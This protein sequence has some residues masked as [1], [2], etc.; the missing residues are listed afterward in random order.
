MGHP[1]F[2]PFFL[3]WQRGK[4]PYFV[5]PVGCEMPPKKMDEEIKKDQDFK[6]IKVTHEYDPEDLQDMSITEDN[7]ENIS[8]QKEIKNEEKSEVKEETEDKKRKLDDQ[9]SELPM[10]KRR[11]MEQTDLVKTGS[12]VFVVTDSLK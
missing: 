9:S 2:I 8:K 3:D 12:G 4:I 10:E 11:K 5:P 7:E 6:E 1:V